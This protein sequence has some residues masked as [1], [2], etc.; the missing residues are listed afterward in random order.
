MAKNR[1]ERARSGGLSTAALVLSL[2][3]I[4]LWLAPLLQAQ[5][6]SKPATPSRGNSANSTTLP[7]GKKLMLKNGTFQLVREYHVEGDRVRYY[8]LDTSQWEEIPLA[9]VDWDKTKKVAAEESAR[10]AAAISKVEVQEAERNAAPLDIDASVEAAPG[11]FLPPGEGLFAFDGKTVLKLAQARIKSSLSK[12]NTIEQVLVPIPV[13]PTRHNISIERPH[14]EYRVTTGQ[15][16]FYMRTSDG[17]EPELELIRASVHGDT[18]QI[19]KLDQLFGQERYTKRTLPMERW[20]IAL[21][22]YRFTLGTPL[23]PGEY[24]LVE[25]V[26]KQS[27]SLYVWDFGVDAPSPSKRK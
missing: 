8:S 19:E 4:V 25:I 17:R 24:A 11:V 18:R 22:L 21:G 1:K 20:Q 5:G 7:R 15:P 14:A 26:Q 9:L 6:T 3:W 2:V 12:K 27:M 13:I 23:A 16:E 10:D